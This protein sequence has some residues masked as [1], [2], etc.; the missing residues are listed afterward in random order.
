[1]RML[2]L[3]RVHKFPQFGR[4]LASLARTQDDAFPRQAGTAGSCGCGHGGSEP[5][6][7]CS[8]RAV[9]SQC[10]RPRSS[11]L[12][13]G[14]VGQRFSR[15]QTG[16]G[17]MQR[18]SSWSERAGRPD[19]PPI[20]VPPLPPRGGYPDPPTQNQCCCIKDVC[21]HT[22]ETS[23]E[24]VVGR[25]R[26]NW[27][28]SVKGQ[29]IEGEG[30]A[31]GLEWYE[32]GSFSETPKGYETWKN[33]SWNDYYR[34]NQE[35]RW[36]LEEL[37]AMDSP[38]FIDGVGISGSAA[39][40]LRFWSGCAVAGCLDCC[41]LVLIEKRPAIFDAPPGPGEQTSDLSFRYKMK[42]S[43]TGLDCDT[44]SIF[45]ESSGR[46]KQRRPREVFETFGVAEG[47]KSFDDSKLSVDGDSGGY[48][49]WSR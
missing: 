13:K 44:P 21:V 23:G 48:H 28:W 2:D 39:L 47:F 11:R 46:R 17:P 4:T 15:L 38:A 43:D 24:R 3:P 36:R 42:C 20:T 27:T 30:G 10:S 29:F 8:D 14:S 34:Q 12:S 32:Y 49:C 33:D 7:E 9:C 37:Q 19:E 40:F 16:M 25:P 35:G 45:I 5:G 18:R 1:M 31:C 26:R 41:V 22:E 6:C